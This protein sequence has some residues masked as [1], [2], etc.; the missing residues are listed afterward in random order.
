[1]KEEEYRTVLKAGYDKDLL[2][3]IHNL[4]SSDGVVGKIISV[5]IDGKIIVEDITAPSAE[6]QKYFDENKDTES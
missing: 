3:N 2:D 5:D 1:M 4:Y 6:A